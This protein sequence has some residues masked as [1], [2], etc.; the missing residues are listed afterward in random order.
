MPNGVS[1]KK[2]PDLSGPKKFHVVDEMDS[3]EEGTTNPILMK[4]RILRVC[5]GS[6]YGLVGELESPPPCHGGDRGFKSRQDR[7]L[8]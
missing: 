2:A 6:N 4:V 1:L 5:W 3:A 7:L 8:L